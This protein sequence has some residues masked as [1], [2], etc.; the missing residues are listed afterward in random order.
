VI[1]DEVPAFVE[2]CGGTA[3]VVWYREMAFFVDGISHDTTPF[4]GVVRSRMVYTFRLEVIGHQLL[5]TLRRRHTT[6]TLVPIFLEFL[7]DPLGGYGFG[8]HRVYESELQ[9]K[10]FSPVIEKR[11]GRGTKS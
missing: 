10:D 5:R 4:F 7:R 11:N 9:E 2:L 1:H 3:I 6:L 8:E